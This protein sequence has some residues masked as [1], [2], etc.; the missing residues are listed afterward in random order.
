MASAEELAALSKAYGPRRV[1]TPNQ[2]IEQFDPLTIQ[3]MLDAQNASV[4]PTLGDMNFSIAT[5]NVLSYRETSC[6]H[7]EEDE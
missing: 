5:P 2:E 6:H 1:K 3:K 7:L 4:S